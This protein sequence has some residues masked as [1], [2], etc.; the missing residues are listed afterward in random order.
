MFFCSTIQNWTAELRRGKI[1]TEDKPRPGRPTITN[2]QVDAVYGI[3]IND[4]GFTIQQIANSVGINYGSFQFIMSG[5]LHI[6]KLVATRIPRRIDKRPKVDWAEYF[7][8][9]FGTFCVQSR[10]F[11]KKNPVAG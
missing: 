3:L 4:R 11:S 6:S 8:R 7:Q 1:I 2:L 5:I 9:A 10:T